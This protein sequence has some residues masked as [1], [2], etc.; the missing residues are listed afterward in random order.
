MPHPALRRTWQV[1]GER[2]GRE[3]L[4]G[5]DAIGYIT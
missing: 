1:W 4:I 2:L 5:I 3:I